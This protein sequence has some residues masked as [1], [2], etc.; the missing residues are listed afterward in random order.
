MAQVKHGCRRHNSLCTALASCM[1]LLPK[2]AHLQ[3]CKMIFKPRRQLRFEEGCRIYK[4]GEG[5]ASA[6]VIQLSDRYG[7]DIFGLF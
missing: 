5:G 7:L 2:C 1:G 4:S 6:Q 3:A